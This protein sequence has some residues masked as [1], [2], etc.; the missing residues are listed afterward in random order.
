MFIK[1]AL[2]NCDIFKRIDMYHH[3]VTEILDVAPTDIF[4]GLSKHFVDNFPGQMLTKEMRDQALDVE[5]FWVNESGKPAMLTAGATIQPTVSCFFQFASHKLTNN[6][7][8]SP[9][10]LY[11]I[12]L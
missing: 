4:N 3:S 5:F 10:V 7:T 8:R 9:F 12:S 1:A 11:L 2:L 6:S